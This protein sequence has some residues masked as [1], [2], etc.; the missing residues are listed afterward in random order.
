MNAMPLSSARHWTVYFPAAEPLISTACRM[1][2]QTLA[3]RLA[4]TPEQVNKHS[5]HSLSAHCGCCLGEQCVDIPNCKN[6]VCCWSLKWFSSVISCFRQA[7]PNWIR[8]CGLLY[9]F[10]RSVV[11]RTQMKAVHVSHIHY[12]KDAS[13]SRSNF[14]GPEITQIC[15]VDEP[16]RV[17]P[18]GITYS[19]N[20]YSHFVASK[21]TWMTMFMSNGCKSEYASS[22]CRVCSWFVDHGDTNI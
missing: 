20:L 17:Y 13:L 16:Y 11:V 6:V 12:S 2:L 3:D 19:Y 21:S 1:S 4:E 5:I 10:M 7:S 9:S 15:H 22:F 14:C 8:S 18:T